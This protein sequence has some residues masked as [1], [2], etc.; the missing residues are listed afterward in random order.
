MSNKDEIIK[1]IE[2][3][4]KAGSKLLA[5]DF[6][7]AD[8]LGSRVKYEDWYSQSLRVIE[9]IV[10]NRRDDFV[11]AYRQPKRKS[12]SHETY[13]ITDY[14]NGTRIMKYDG[15]ES[16]PHSTIYSNLMLMQISILKSAISV[17][18]SKIRDINATLEAELF[19]DH[20]DAAKTLLKNKFVRC[21]GAVAGVVLENHLKSICI[22]HNQ[23]LKKA[24]PSIADY[25]NALKDTVYDTPTWRLI[26]RLGDIRNLCVH[27]KDREP[28]AD[29]VSDLIKGTE[30]VIKEVF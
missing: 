30:K 8:A 4:V 22:S 3:L 16:I 26:E 25:N 13:S 5:V 18:D 29:E 7:K 15:T 10:P 1:E 12:I 20:L 27:S 23:L 2:S 21:S 19:D 14:L 9:Q 28:T 17:A 6:D 11:S 24:N